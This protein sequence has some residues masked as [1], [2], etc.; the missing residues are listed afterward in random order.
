MTKSICN[1]K[2]SE[3]SYKIEIKNL[4]S[5]NAAEV[6][7]DF[8]FP[9]GIDFV[10]ATA[11]YSIGATGPSGALTNTSA[12]ANNPLLGGFTI[13]LNGITTITLKGKITAS[14]TA[15]IKV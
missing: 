9:A 11:I 14:V 8:V 4:G 15:G 7:L 3:V 10:S 13:A 6:F 5:G 2:N 1:S 12:I